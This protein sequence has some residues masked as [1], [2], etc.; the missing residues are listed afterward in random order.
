MKA[1]R[2]VDL[3]IQERIR[4]F[5]LFIKYKPPN[6][7]EYIKAERTSKYIANN[8]KQDEKSIVYYST[9]GKKYNGN[10]PAEVIFRPHY[11]AMREDLDNCRCKGLLDGL[12]A[13]GVIKNDNLKH[14]QRIVYEPVFDDKTGIEIIIKEL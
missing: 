7:N 9:M 3:K 6:W 5:R 4:E 10:Y 1:R 11:S 8:I 14:I 13:A 12:V 2:R